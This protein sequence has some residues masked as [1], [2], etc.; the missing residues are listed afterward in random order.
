M[1]SWTSLLSGAVRPTPEVTITET[2]A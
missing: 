1:P 2:V